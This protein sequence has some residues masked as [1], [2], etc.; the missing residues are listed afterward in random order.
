MLLKGLNVTKGDINQ[1][2][3]KE[4]YL[5]HLKY[6]GDSLHYCTK[7]EVI[8]PLNRSKGNLKTRRGVG[9]VQEQV[10][11]ATAREGRQ[12]GLGSQEEG[13]AGVLQFLLQHR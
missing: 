4:G 1:F 10:L 7:N 6:I 8:E 12:A 13:A 11:H 9:G 2:S 3:K 5:S